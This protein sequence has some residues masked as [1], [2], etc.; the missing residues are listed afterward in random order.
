M[1]GRFAA[2]NHPDLLMEYYR[3]QRDATAGQVVLPNFN[4]APTQN[5]LVVAESAE[6]DHSRELRVMKW[7]LV[8]SWASDPSIGNR[9][10]N[11]R[12]ETAMS[13][14][15]FRHA[16]ARHRC[17]IPVDGFYEWQAAERS[18]APA[19][20]GTTGRPIKQPYY[21]HPADGSSL[22]VAGLFDVWHD[23]SGANPLV[24][25][26]ILTT[27]AVGAMTTIHD[28]IP[29]VIEPSN[30][31]V[32]LDPAITD[33]QVASS[34]MQPASVIPLEAV[35]VSR[36]VNAVSHHGA[37]LIAPLDPSELPISL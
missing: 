11:A 28:R 18:D 1:C 32:W 17:L 9:M 19:M 6:P 7:G 30:W 25:C 31:D 37:E 4:T 14:P 27:Q 15:S 8:P 21:I 36:E 29:V 24:T 20:R 34:L 26:T 12:S 23:P 33:K 22:P 5:L 2:G 35:R 3:V 10:I 16:F 13:K